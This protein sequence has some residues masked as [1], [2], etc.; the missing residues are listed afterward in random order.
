MAAN[1]VTPKVL[2]NE[3]GID[4]KRLRAFLRANFTR[5]IEVKNTSWAIT[6]QAANAA[7]KHFA[8]Q[9]TPEK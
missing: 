6:P 7:R 1:I 5:S 8:K 4:P 3:L 2:A 9:R